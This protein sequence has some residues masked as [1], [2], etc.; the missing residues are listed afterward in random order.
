M[1]ASGEPAVTQ[2]VR[3]YH[4]LGAWL[5]ASAALLGTWCVV[6]GFVA[7]D[8]CSI[9]QQVSAHIGVMLAGGLLKFGYVVRLAAEH[10]ARQ[11][12]RA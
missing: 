5:M 4:R 7:A 9:P 6:V 8:A 10:E 2:K 11:P 3:K 1:A 12:A